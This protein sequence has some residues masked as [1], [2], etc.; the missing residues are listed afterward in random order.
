MYLEPVQGISA[1]LQASGLLLDDL[2]LL[3]CLV[4]W[5]VAATGKLL[6]WLTRQTPNYITTTCGNAWNSRLLRITRP[7]VH[8]GASAAA[9]FLTKIGRTI[10]NVVATLWVWLDA[11]LAQRAAHHAALRRVARVTSENES[12]HAQ[13]ASLQQ[14]IATL[15]MNVT[16]LNTERA[17][18]AV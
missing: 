18:S 10:Y 15:M 4:F 6:S 12:L 1:L 14:K 16:R 11:V 8:L 13:I 17:K 3:L 5:P 2:W 9:R 7:G